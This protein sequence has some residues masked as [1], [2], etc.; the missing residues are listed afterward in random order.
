M[1]WNNLS[2][3]FKHCC[4]FFTE[5][6]SSADK[7]KS[8]TSACNGTSYMCAGYNKIAKKQTSICVKFFYKRIMKN[9][10]NSKWNVSIILVSRINIIFIST[11]T[12]ER[13]YTNCPFLLY[14]VCNP[15][16]KRS[17]DRRE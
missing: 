6:I 11:K 10:S 17:R 1:Q 2:S 9:T 12:Y 3:K 15:E 5:I 8:V 14:I 7:H 16:F 4:K 13:G